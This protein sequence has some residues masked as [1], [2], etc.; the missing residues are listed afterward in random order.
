MTDKDYMQLAL[1]LARQAEGRTTPNPLVGAVIV[2]GGKIVGQGY[3]HYAG[4]PHA[5][6][7]A[8]REAGKDAKGAIVYLTLE[9]CSHYGKTPPCANTLIK[10]EVKKV[11]IAM[12]DPNPKV[13]GNGIKLLNEAGIETEVGLLKEE[14]KKLNEVFLKYITTNR[15]FVILKNAMTLDGRIATKTGDSKWITGKESRALVHRIRDKVDGILVGVG[16]VLADNPRLTTRLG[17][18]GEDPIRIILDSSLEIPLD[19]KVINQD[20]S[21]Q[22]I[23]ATVKTSNK[24]KKMRLENLGVEIIEA[25]ERGLVDLDILLKKLGE[26]EI[27]SLLVEG[28]SRVNSSFLEERLVDKIYYFIAPKIIGGLDAIPVLGGK[29]VERIEEGIKLVDKKITQLGDD[30]LIV[31]Y[32]Q[33]LA[34]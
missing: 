7:N 9:P 1:D 33:Y 2:K 29:G 17:E 11:V 16:T 25:G 28:G 18:G 31:A 32:P 6:I 20:S 13:A 14:A 26:R 34:K 21:A 5:E 12:E 10:A 15:P 24:E 4:G 19:A 8:L 23:I 3:H 30:I 22:T 27:T